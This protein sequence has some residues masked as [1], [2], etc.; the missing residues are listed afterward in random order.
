MIQF[1]SIN[2]VHSTDNTKSMLANP[3]PKP[4]VQY[5]IAILM[6]DLALFVTV[7]T[8][9]LT[10]DWAMPLWKKIEQS[11]Q[12]CASLWVISKLSAFRVSW[13]FYDFLLE[14]W[15]FRVVISTIKLPSRFLSINRWHVQLFDDILNTWI[16]EPSLQHE[17]LLRY[18]RFLKAGISPPN[19][20][21]TQLT[22]AFF[23]SLGGAT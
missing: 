9:H 11:F 12:W 6:R 22:I 7:S 19:A 21:F 4:T 17:R 16:C 14:M 13:S 20:V 10:K 15:K 18:R 2:G 8:N 3:Q 1:S 5:E 23:S